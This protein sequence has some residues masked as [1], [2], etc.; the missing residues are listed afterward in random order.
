MSTSSS[1][2][3]LYT[4][5][6]C[7]PNP[8]KGGYGIVLIEDG[9][10]RELSGGFEETTNNRMELLSI[11]TG[12]EAVQGRGRDIVVVSD[13]R[14]VVDA[15]SSGSAHQ[16]QARNWMRTKRDAAKNPDLWTNLLSVCEN[17]IVEMKWVAGH[18][19]HAEN[20]RCDVLA[21]AARLRDDLP[22]DEGYLKP[23]DSTD[24]GQTQFD[25]FKLLKKA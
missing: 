7:S 3:L 2:I 8:G 15:Y 23:F 16:W 19:G 20:E 14:Y 12:I 11:I 6:A 17:H 18:M 10:R 22:A 9:V 1:P 21:V 4:D 25:L 13:S 24:L 5:G